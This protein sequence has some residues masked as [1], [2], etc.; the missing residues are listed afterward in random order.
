MVCG[1]RSA[2]R[3]VYTDPKDVTAFQAKTAT[4]LKRALKDSIEDYLDF[5]HERDEGPNKPFSGN[6]P[7]RTTPA[8]H[9]FLFTLSKAKNTSMS[10]IIE[11]ILKDRFGEISNE[12]LAP[13]IVKDIFKKNASL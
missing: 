13:K 7:V 3:A 12:N 10:K 6:F 2:F 1:H 8:V 11:E 9:H 4:Q 5:C